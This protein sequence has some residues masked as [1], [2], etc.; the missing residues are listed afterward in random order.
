MIP[1]E[2]NFI[3][4]DWYFLN[5]VDDY[6][7]CLIF[8]LKIH[9]HWIIFEQ[10]VWKRYEVV[11]LKRTNRIGLCPNCARHGQIFEFDDLEIMFP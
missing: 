7:R 10:S 4:K 2:T 6:G 5:V 1:A 9:L 11:F 3:Q 8:A